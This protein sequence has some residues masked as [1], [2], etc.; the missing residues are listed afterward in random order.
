MRPRGGAPEKRDEL[1]PLHCVV[2]ERGSSPSLALCDG[3]ASEKGLRPNVRGGSIATGRGKLQIQQC[4][5]CSNRYRNGEPLNPTRRANDRDRGNP[6]G[7]SPFPRRTY[8]SVHGGSRSYLRRFDQGRETERFEV[9]I[10]GATERALLR[11]MYQGPRPLHRPY[12]ATPLKLAVRS[13][14][15]DGDAGFPLTP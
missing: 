13:G 3:A 2:L 1:A 12:F 15:H 4:P 9:N 11:A 8:G 7:C 10:G 6:H 14:P 5:L